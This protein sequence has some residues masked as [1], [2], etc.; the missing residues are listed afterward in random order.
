MPLRALLVATLAAAAAAQCPSFGPYYPTGTLP[1]GLLPAG[2]LSEVSGMVASRQQPGVLWVH[3]DSGHG[4]IVVGIRSDGSLVQQYTLTNAPS[5]D[6]EDIALGPGPLAGRDYLYLADCGNNNLNRTSFSLVRIAEPTPPASPGNPIALAGAEVFPFTY[7]GAAPDTEALFVD[8]VD[9][10]PY[11]ISKDDTQAVL[12]R[13]PLPLTANTTRTLVQ[14]LNLVLPQYKVTGADITADGSRIHL[15]T[16]RQM[17]LFSRAPGTTVAQALAGTPCV[18]FTGNLGQVESVAVE[19]DGSGLLTVAEGVGSPILRASALGP[20][21]YPAWWSYGQGAP[22]LLGPVGFGP[23]Q[24]ARLG[25]APITLHVSSGSPFAGALCALSLWPVPYGT[26]P[27]A[28]GFVL[29]DPTALFG[30]GLNG[31]GAGGVAMPPV[32]N[33]PGLA[34]IVLYAQA[35]VFDAWAPGGISLTRGLAL[36]LGF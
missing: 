25:G 26:R 20:T 4:P 29:V 22:G 34:G 15:R 17:L 2:T 31:L 9:G 1:T 21:A 12:Y 3:D 23:N 32:P 8:P 19:P 24:V 35:F 28:N 33:D 14:E 16:H 10:T 5:V 11:L 13:Y 7:P 27:L 6:W 30:F 18:L 36:R